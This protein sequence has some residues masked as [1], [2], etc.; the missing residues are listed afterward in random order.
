MNMYPGGF[1]YYGSSGF[2]VTDG[3]AV[4]G[5]FVGFYL[6]FLFLS[7]AFSVVTYVLH[8]LG[9]YTMAKRRG[10]H[11]PW[12]AWLP[13]GSE[14]ILGSIGDQYQYVAKGQ[15]RNRRKVLLGLEVAVYA[16][17]IAMYICAVATVV[18]SAMSASDV[19]VMS[20]LLMLL[21]MVAVLVLAII[22]AIFVYIGYYNLFASC[23]PENAVMYL[24]LGIIFPVTM[25]FFVFICR[26]SDKGMP[27]R[28]PALPTPE[29]QPEPAAEEVVSET[30]A[31]EVVSEPEAPAEE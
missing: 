30:V 17:A 18:V 11:H 27:P 24:V 14:W 8:A 16:V 21:F 3:G 10:I 31:E 5:M 26:K 13:I 29:Y 23:Q 7:M 20:A 9:L 12:L 15:V 2:G 1:D 4:F 19:M 25:P 22:L 6:L 28:K